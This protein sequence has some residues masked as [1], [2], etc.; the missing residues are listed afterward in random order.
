MNESELKRYLIKSIRAQ[1]G[2]GHRFE[3]KFTIGWPD[4]L[5]IPEKGPVFFV[6]VKLIR[7]AKLVAT[8]IQA[9]QLDRLSRPKA[10]G[11]YFCH[12]V[13]IGYHAGKEALYIG[14]PQQL[15][16]HCRFVPRPRVLNSAEWLISELLGKWESYMRHLMPL[17]PAL[18]K[19]E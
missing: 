17:E 12:G 4:C 1:G 8:E 9:V 15:L 18:D 3:D 11:R 6:E 16:V 19:T 5:F 14:Q 7:G 10:H 2:V 13:V